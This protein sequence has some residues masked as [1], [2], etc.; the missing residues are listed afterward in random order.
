M[1][2]AP[3]LVDKYATALRFRKLS[4][5]TI[6]GYIF[7]LRT[8][9]GLI[10]RPFLIDTTHVLSAGDVWEAI[11]KRSDLSPATLHRWVAAS[12]SWHKWGNS[13]DL[14]PLNGIMS[15]EV[16]RVERRAPDSLAPHEAQWLIERATTPALK[17]VILLPLFEGC[18]ISGAARIDASSFL[19][20][21]EPLPGFV[22]VG[23]RLHF[24]EKGKWGE[25]PLH[26]VVARELDE[27]LSVQRTRRQLRWEAEK[28][29]K[30][31]PFDWFPHK[32][33]ATFCQTLMNNRERGE[34]VDAL[35]RHEPKSTAAKH[36]GNEPWAPRVE[37]MGRVH[38]RHEQLH[39]F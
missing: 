17:R 5:R 32:L 31:T 7:D 36:Y 12:R 4:E 6:D 21:R 9:E 8:I 37:A 27:I 11:E 22:G 2:T 24:F 13:R 39:L 19:T 35:M 14:W 10:E 16:T 15:I 38:Y 1:P 29:Q 33:R 3:T 28:L 25:V 26:P 18:R 23:P 30:W 34:T 20:S